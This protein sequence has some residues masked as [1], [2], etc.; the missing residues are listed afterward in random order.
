MAIETAG[1]KKGPAVILVLI[2][3]VALF[4]IV[5]QAMPK[6]YYY[7]TDLKCESCG[8]VFQQK[9]ASGTAFPIKCPKCGE[10]TAQKAMKCLDCGEIFTMKP[11]PVA[12]GAPGEMIPPEMEMPKCPKCGSMNLGPVSEPVK[13]VSEP[14]E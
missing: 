7:T 10:I 8:A 12:P 5:K 3:L 1:Q 14:E 2:I 9:I 4:F 6:K 13:P 11:P